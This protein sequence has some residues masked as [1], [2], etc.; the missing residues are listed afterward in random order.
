MTINTF[1]SNYWI[2]IAALGLAT[3]NVY[4]HLKANKTERK[5]NLQTAYMQLTGIINDFQVD[6]LKHF[7]LEP[8]VMNLKL[9]I[10]EDLDNAREI[11]K[12]VEQVKKITLLEKKDKFINSLAKLNEDYNRTFDETLKTKLREEI[13]I[14]VADVEQLVKDYRAEKL[15]NKPFLDKAVDIADLAEK[16]ILIFHESMPQR[17]ISI[18]EAVFDLI[19]DLNSASTWQLIASK[20]TIKLVNELENAAAN[21]NSRI[22]KL[23]TGGSDKVHI[24]TIV[25]SEEFRIVWVLALKAIKKMRSEI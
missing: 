18:S 8:E 12:N 6:C 13:K 7:H 5:K 16:K 17:V 9:K 2:Y 11:L 3:W 24:E 25:K 14:K 21:L 4:L 23:V 1:L 19:Y 20:S 10:S 15:K 22:L